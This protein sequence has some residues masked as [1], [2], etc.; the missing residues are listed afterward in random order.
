MAKN[1]TPAKTGAPAS[2]EK[3]TETTPENVPATVDATAAAVDAPA[4]TTTTQGSTMATEKTEGASTA[5]I[6]AQFTAVAVAAPAPA[7]SGIVQNKALADR[8]PARYRED[9]LFMQRPSPEQLFEIVMKLPADSQQKMLELVRKTRPKKQGAHTAR[10][11]FSPTQLRVNQG[12]G[13]DPVKPAKHPPGNFYTTDSRDMGDEV[14]VV[15][16][17]FYEGRT[18]WPPRDQGDSASKGPLCFSLDRKMGTRYGECEACPNAQKK[19]TEGGCGR[20][21]TAWFL[22]EDM[23]G[24]YEVKFSKSSIGMGDSL[25][26][27]LNKA[28]N[29]WDRWFTLKNDARSEGDRR[30]YV[31]KSTPFTDPKNPAASNTDR[32]LHTLYE[33]LSRLLDADVYFPAL[34]DTYD[35]AKGSTDAG[36]AVMANADEAALLSNTATDGTPDYSG[37]NPNV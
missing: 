21:V 17:G 25:V 14:K 27:I 35:R 8:L 32:A 15:F 3:L 7:E 22:D 10:E 18:M 34:A 26:K 28:D 30:W 29:L 5:L 11:G 6:P 16:I 13:N 37:D 12:T 20:E 24:I 1:T 33:G 4:S 19:Y 23:T 9:V 36:G 31:T 2:V